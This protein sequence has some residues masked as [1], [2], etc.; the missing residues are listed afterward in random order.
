MIKDMISRLN[1]EAT[2]ETEHKGWCDAELGANKI[3][4]DSKTDSVASLTAEKDLHLVDLASERAELGG[5]LDAAVSRVLSSGR[6]ILGPE[7]EAFEQ[8]IQV[9]LAGGG[10]TLDQRL[11]RARTQTYQVRTAAMLDVLRD[12]DLLTDGGCEAPVPSQ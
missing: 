11:A 9:A 7:V 3:T 8:A 2:A 1:Q 12:K 4:R 6:Y 10:P 5:E